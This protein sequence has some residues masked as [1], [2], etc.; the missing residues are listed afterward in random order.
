[1]F[2]ADFGKDV[3]RDFD[4]GAHRGHDYLRFSK[5]L[6]SSFDSVMSAARQVGTDVVITTSAGD[7][8]ALW[9]VR[10]ADLVADDFRFF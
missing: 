3:I 1:V 6:F 10:K 7:S 8:L 4:E 9:N 5:A 2:K